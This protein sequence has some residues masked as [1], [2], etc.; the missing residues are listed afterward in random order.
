MNKDGVI[1]IK[2]RYSPLFEEDVTYNL[3]HDPVTGHL[4][5]FPVF[6]IR[7]YRILESL[8]VPS[9]IQSDCAENSQNFEVFVN[10]QVNCFI[11][12]VCKKALM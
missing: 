11:A 3:F 9:V 6:A 12:D 2:K 4:S 1:N 7:S 8:K 5:K 10:Y